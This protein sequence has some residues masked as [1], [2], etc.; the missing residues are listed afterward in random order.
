MQTT[1][2]TSNTPADTQPARK[3][4]SG[5]DGFAALLVGAQAASVQ[6][7]SVS[8]SD[9]TG[10][11][12][13][14]AGEEPDAQRARIDGETEAARQKESE[15][16][17]SDSQQSRADA[18]RQAQDDKPVTQEARATS[19][20]PAG[21]TAPRA[22]ATKIAEPAQPVEQT[23]KSQ[24]EPEEKPIAS[25]NDNP[26]PQPQTQPA[27]SDASPKAEVVAVTTAGAARAASADKATAT[28]AAQA[29]GRTLANSAES[30]RSPVQAAAAPSAARDQ[31]GS[32]APT[33]SNKPAGQQSA[34]QQA[35]TTKSSEGPQRS[36]FLKLIQNLRLNRGQKTSTATLRIEPPELGKMKVDVRMTDDTLHVRVEVG[37]EHARRV[38]GERAD[39]LA[40]ALRTHD[41]KVDRFEVV[42]VDAGNAQAQFDGHTPQD[43]HDSSAGNGTNTQPATRGAEASGVDEDETGVVASTSAEIDAL[44]LVDVRA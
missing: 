10:L 40:A 31:T 3:R 25:A 36:E 11:A 28:T 43:A 9:A 26:R 38:L 23:A 19:E 20:K 7:N 13:Q 30:V 29:I 44:A 16:S 35:E 8:V 33:K 27:K 2:V 24:A 21:E 17:R 18:L 14:D 22:Q 1:E 15:Q 37:S 39:D 6:M 42:R 34:K 41:I 5:D 12:V 4:R 32:Q